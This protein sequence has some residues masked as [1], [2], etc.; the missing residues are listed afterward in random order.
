MKREIASDPWAR[1]LE[2]CG[3]EGREFVCCVAP[4]A[5]EPQHVPPAGSR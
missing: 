5:T 2:R 3:G 4:N 1:V